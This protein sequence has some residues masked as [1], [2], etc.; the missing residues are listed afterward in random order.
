[1]GHQVELDVLVVLAAGVLVVE[2][3]DDAVDSEDD[4]LLLD[5]PDDSDVDAVLFDVDPRLSV[6]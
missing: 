5:S 2:L 4:E 3:S 6:L 1:V